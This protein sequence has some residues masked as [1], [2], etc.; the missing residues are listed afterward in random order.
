MKAQ[1]LLKFL[2]PF[3]PSGWRTAGGVVLLA[4]GTLLSALSGPDLFGILPADWQPWAQVLQG[5]G[6]AAAALGLR[7]SKQ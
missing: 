7:F 3:V 6:A 5:W 4:V 1:G 2:L